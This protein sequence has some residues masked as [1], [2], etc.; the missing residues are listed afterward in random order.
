VVHAVSPRIT[1]PA[2]RRAKNAIALAFADAKKKAPEMLAKA[3]E[4]KEHAPELWQ[5]AKE[6]LAVV[7]EVLR[8]KLS[9]EWMDLGRT[10][11]RKHEEVHEAHDRVGTKPVA[12][13]VVAAAE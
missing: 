5:M 13:E 3:M 2:W 11:L 10:V 4:A 8:G 1:T 9:E 6:D 7:G 12:H